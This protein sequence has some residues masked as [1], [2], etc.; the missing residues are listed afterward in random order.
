MRQ[1][2]AGVSKKTGKPYNAFM[3]CPNQ[4]KQNQTQ[5]APNVQVEENN[6]ENNIRWCNAI[7]NACLLVAHGK[8]EMNDLEALAN[9]I[10][11]LEPQ[12]KAEPF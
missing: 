6:V 12:S 8:M 3:A 10:Y 11:K 7:N 4:C 5:T 1:I 2:P 9:R